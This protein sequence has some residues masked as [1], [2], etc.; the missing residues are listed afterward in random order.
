MELSD[1]PVLE[2]VVDGDSPVKGVVT[3]S[4]W[5]AIADLLGAIQGIV[6]RHD[7]GDG[8]GGVTPP[9]GHVQLASDVV[10]VLLSLRQ[11]L[12]QLL[13]STASRNLDLVKEVERLKGQVTQLEERHRESVAML[14]R[15]RD[16]ETRLREASEVQ[17][18][19]AVVCEQLRDENTRL[20]GRLRV[21]LEDA[22]AMVSHVMGCVVCYMVPSMCVVGMIDLMCAVMCAVMCDVMCAVMCA[23]IGL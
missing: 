16:V 15:S 23:V 9:P 14:E 20:R 5:E 4:D 8:G 22:R 1:R 18:Q 3:S 12:E 2:E 6:R 10:T 7:D 21:E 17:S 13:P 19:Q 11:H